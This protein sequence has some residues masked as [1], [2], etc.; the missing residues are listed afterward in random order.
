MRVLITGATGFV[1][2]YLA[3]EIA[4]REPATEIWGTAHGRSHVVASA[5]GG[6][7]TDA[8]RLIAGDLTDPAFTAQ[9]VE[10]V[11]PDRVY[12]LAGFA[13]GAG[14]DREGIFAANVTVTGELLRL[15]SRAG[16]PCRVLLA[17]S[18]YVYGA[19]RAGRPAREE[20]PLTPSG[21]YAESKAAMEEAARRVADETDVLE[22][23]VARA[24]NHTGPRQTADFVVPAFAAQIA[25]IERG[26]A[27]PRL[28]VGNL[29]AR[30]DF[31]DVRDVVR[32]YRMLLDGGGAPYRVV[33]VASGVA[34]TIR[35]ILDT[36][37]REARV[38]LAVET[39]PARLRPS[40][41]PECVGDPSR[42]VA[43]TQ[44]K[45]EFPLEATLRDT[46]SY[47]R[48]QPSVPRAAA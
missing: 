22:V 9:V 23:T 19:T 48:D 41:I 7:A 17:S 2:G 28:R 32:A 14:T 35:A 31:L 47:W 24:F 16:R 5:P 10:T 37:L 38:P 27:P 43:L 11:R 36:L 29:D 46:L 13:S 25:E 40:D 15:L 18:G 45:P 34:V 21:A 8:V 30:R 44:W 33:N 6:T 20:D 4:A 12:H 3:G 39:D 42:L 1:G 26:Q